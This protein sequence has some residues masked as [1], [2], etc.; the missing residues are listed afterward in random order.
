MSPMPLQYMRPQ[1]VPNISPM[2]S[3]CVLNASLMRP[4]GLKVR[5]KKGYLWSQYG[6][7]REKKH[8]GILKIVIENVQR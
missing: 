8:I 6:R 5:Q 3:Q 1:C 7:N 4:Q 2:R